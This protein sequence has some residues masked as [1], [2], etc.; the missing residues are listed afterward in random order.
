MN[1]LLAALVCSEIFAVISELKR[2]T[3]STVHVLCGIY[4]SIQG[5]GVENGSGRNAGADGDG[6]MG[7]NAGT[8]KPEGGNEISAETI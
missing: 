2:S 3:W 7:G 5:K 4:F 6:M 8:D 1:N